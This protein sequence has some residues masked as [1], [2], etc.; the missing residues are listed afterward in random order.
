M[1]MEFTIQRHDTSH[2]LRYLAE[3]WQNVTHTTRNSFCD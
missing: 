2:K 3:D 1:P